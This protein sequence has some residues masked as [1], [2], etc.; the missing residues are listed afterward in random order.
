MRKL[1]RAHAGFC[2]SRP[3]G[4]RRDGARQQAGRRGRARAR[5][6]QQRTG[7]GQRVINRYGCY[8]CHEI[9][10]FETTQ[11]IGVDLSEEGSKLVTRLDFAFISDI[12]HTSKLA[13]FKRKLQDP[14][15]TDLLARAID[16]PEQQVYVAAM[17]GVYDRPATDAVAEALAWAWDR[18]DTN[19]AAAATPAA[20]ATASPP[21]GSEPTRRS[22]PPPPIRATTHPSSGTSP[23]SRSTGSRRCCAPPRGHACRSL[24]LDA[25]CARP[26]VRWAW[27]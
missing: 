11:P 10:G 20:P 3:V 1:E 7:L 26:R 21:C 24:A 12:P 19:A 23:S 25:W 27:R 18:S 9:K 4:H 14:R 15:V 17:E 13:W 2:P 5:Q 16:D 22:T 8:S 6:Q